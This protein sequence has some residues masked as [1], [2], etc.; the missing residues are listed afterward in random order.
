M[1]CPGDLLVVY[2]D[3]ITEAESPSGMPFDD[4]GVEE[5]VTQH[6]TDSAQ[7]VA[8]ALMARVESHIGDARV[9]DDSTILALRH[10]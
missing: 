6:A 5:T 7:G 4:A 9:C 10:N 2:S 3:G 8:R 1:L